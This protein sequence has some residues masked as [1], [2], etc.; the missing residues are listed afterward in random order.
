MIIDARSVEDA[1]SIETELCIVGAGA[2]GISMARALA[3]AG[4]RTVLLESGGMTLD[5][6]TQDLNAG[7]NVGL[8]YFPLVGTRLRFFGGTTNHWGGTCRPFDEADFTG[9]PGVPNTTWPITLADVAPYYDEAARIV[10]LDASGFDAETWKERSP[11]RPFDLDDGV[12]ETRVAKVVDANDR[13]FNALY[14]DEIE[15]AGSV[16]TYL[17]ANVTDVRLALDQASV[18]SVVVA[19]GSGTFTVRARAFVLAAGGIENARILLAS[20]SQQPAGI[21]NGY[22]VV[23]RYFLEHPRFVGGVILPIDPELSASFYEPHVVD[24]ARILGYL[25]LSLARRQEEGLVDVQFRTRTILDPAS[26]R[27]RASTDVEALRRL[28]DRLR[29]DE[30]LDGALGDVVR[31]LDD[32]TSW[33]RLLVPGAGAPV[34]QPELLRVLSEAS[35]DELSALVPE[36]FGDIA[37]FAYGRVTDS[38]S[39]RAIELS[40]RLDP[41]PIPDSR[42]T[43]GDERDAFGMPRVQLDWQL[44]EVDRRSAIH[45][46]EAL[47]QEV[48][49]AGIGRVQ[50]QIE[51]DGPW[52]SDTQGGY[53][54]MGTTRMSA[55]PRTGVVDADCRV[56]GLA[57][58]YVAGSSVFTTGGSATPTMTLIALSLR[59]ADH[60][61]ELFA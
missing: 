59:L 18:E 25:S 39:V 10:Q 8:P 16:T 50:M 58:L 56:H 44:S 45:A 12:I 48:G 29:G 21:G 47:G 32:L 52:P 54:H 26:E 49:R 38:A 53:H 43:L 17:H 11:Y 57:N 15:R 51:A 13:S 24:D 41:A 35:S 46:L 37:V 4:F 36:F 55:D 60:L 33:R 40:T 23:G 42:V 31:V 30:D 5:G 6:V 2:A 14:A 7:E 61:R 3:D 22:D 34:P 27:A 9:L 1:A 20:N 28:A 19:T